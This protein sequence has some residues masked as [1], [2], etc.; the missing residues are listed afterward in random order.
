MFPKFFGRNDAADPAT[1]AGM[2]AKAE[3]E[4]ARDALSAEEKTRWQEK[5]AQAS[6]DDAALL[7]LAAEAP[8][9]EI[10]HA[11]VQG[12]QSEDAV[13]S[14]ER[15]FRDHD[16][17][18]HREAKQKLDT[19]V[20]TREARASASSL[21]AGGEA[22]LTEATIP[23]NRLVELDHAWRALPAALLGDPL[24]VRYQQLAD[25]LA[26]RVRER[27]ESQL[28]IKRWLADADRVLAYHT[29]ECLSA[30]REGA[31]S[32]ALAAAGEAIQ[33]ALATRPSGNQHADVRAKQQALED[34][35]Q[36]NEAV[37]ARLSFLIRLT[38]PDT[39]PASVQDEWNATPATVSARLTAPIE[40]RFADWLS[41]R[42]SAK[43]SAKTEA[44]QNKK[45][46]SDKARDEARAGFLAVLANAEQALSEGHLADAV[47]HLGKLDE[48]DTKSLNDKKLQGRVNGLQ[49]EVARLKGWQHWG[50]GRVRDDLAEAAEKLA[51]DATSEKLNLKLHGDAVNLLRERWKE[52]DKLGGA[53]NRELWERFD[54]ALK[55]AY[56]PIAEQLAKLK[57]QRQD[58][59]AERN[60]LL[61][62]LD[63]V[64]ATDPTTPDWRAATR[65]L[66]Q[67]QIAWR[68][69]GPLEHTVPTKAKAALVERQLKSVA[70]LEAPL[71]AARATEE[72]R[73]QD[74]IAQA[75][76]LSSDANA[77]DA[78]NKVRELQKQWQASAQAL[79]LARNHETKL[80]A[81]F[82][83]ATDAVFEQRDA[84]GKAREAGWKAE[85]VRREELIGQLTA[86]NTESPPEALR[87]TLA[88]V[89][90]EWR[91]GEASRNDAAKLDGQYR[92]AREAAQK[93]LAGSA[94]RGWQRLCDALLKKCALA[95]Q[96]A[97]DGYNT[98]WAALPP[99]ST[100]WEKALETRRSAATAA[101]NEALLQLE[102]ALD[103]PSPEAY[104][105]ARRDLKLRAMKQAIEARAAPTTTD[106]DIERWVAD[107]VAST[108]AASDS[109]FIKIMAALGNRPLKL[110]TP[111][112]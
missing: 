72:A 36:D 29:E 60:K 56:V 57:A 50:G 84:A 63:A 93:L 69:L 102:M 48:L 49:A 44:R 53:T 96:P 81:N 79:P 33:T 23:A 34:A 105:S 28:A 31:T 25:A 61:D 18:V 46:Q 13:K 107:V 6:G 112:R 73:R 45:Q 94:T 19:L 97:Q 74:L 75:K 59:L 55:L 111:K 65:A 3:A 7:A 99:L 27:G 77:R 67:F 83:A 16:R 41:A 100:A 32:P 82:K 26:S 10:R 35:K 98:Q 21:L 12:L 87:K 78:I 95:E 38:H 80:W 101:A 43:Q 89:D 20:A 15:A 64:A 40:Q 37:V 103:L 17:R 110:P 109:R 1:P 14:A 11:A 30:I 108:I 2:A 22:L 51:K 68:K 70:R 58:N 4:A 106:A 52:V 91:K 66:E 8:L 88:S 39:L 76:T 90:Q 92:V 104:A 47:K 24:T 71:S 54:N 42:E 5:L 85:R 86:L 9:L 62:A